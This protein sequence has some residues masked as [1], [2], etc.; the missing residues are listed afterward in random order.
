MTCNRE[1]A[2][3][4]LPRAVSC[5]G[6]AGMTVACAAG[7]MDAALHR[8]TKWPRG[9][10]WG[11]AGEGRRRGGEDECE[12]QLGTCAR[13]A[14]RKMPVPILPVLLGGV[15]ISLS[16]ALPYSY[17]SGVSIFLTHALPYPY[18]SGVLLFSPRISDEHVVASHLFGIE[19][20]PGLLRECERGACVCT[21]AR[22]RTGRE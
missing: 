19:R 1:R 16:H 2:W 11:A 20:R 21:C 18:L 10:G 13:T 12:S 6:G 4:C 9:G 7:G 3:P 14:I 22:R 5:S 8:L 15:S 17:L